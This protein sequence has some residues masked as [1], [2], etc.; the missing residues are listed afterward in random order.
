MT[1]PGLMTSAPLLVSSLIDHAARHHRSGEIVSRLGD[2]SLHRYRYPDCRRRAMRLASALQR[3][4]I[5]PGARI[6][7]IAWNGFR[8]LELYF[9]VGGMGAV[10]HTINPRLHPEQVA[11]IINHAA[12]Q[13]VFFDVEFTGLIAQIAPLCP[14]V[15]RWVALCGPTEMPEIPAGAKV[16]LESYELLLE[17][18]GEDYEW[19]LLEESAACG[20]CYTSGTTGQPKGVLYTHRSTVLHAYAASLPNAMNLSSHS[21]VLPV[22]PMFHVNAWGIPYAAPLNG[23]K[24][25]LPG[26]MLD[27]PSLYALMESEGV[28][29]A[30]GVPTIWLSLLE[31][32]EKSAV[33]F[34]A[35]QEAAIGGSACPA[36][37]VDRFH[38]VGVDVVHGWGMTETSPLGCLSRLGSGNA[39]LSLNQRRHILQKQGHA[40]FGIDMKIV[41][42]S[43]DELPWDGESFGDLM[44]RGPWVL[45]RYY[46]EDRPAGENGWFATG[47][48]AT[49]DPAG[50]MQI[51]DRTKD[52]IKSGG[53][54]I[55]SIDI[56]SIAM[57]HPGLQ[58]A[59]CIGAEHPKWG[60]RPLLIAVARPD[61]HLS[62]SDVLHF[63]E[64]KAAKWWIPDEVIFVESLPHN[65][66]G[67]VQKREL[68]DQYAGYFA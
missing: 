7:T 10:C 67:K 4:G 36:S 12:D 5:Q 63:F 9:G 14:E 55:S 44:V 8:H 57:A 2:G 16:S 65:A 19:P 50:S 45:E 25:V 28:T 59:A 52:I 35:L 46:G 40:L 41:N 38:A 49:I 32:V 37:L 20:L 64:G 17:T 61:T 42:G 11:Y 13:M 58:E 18:G 30:A 43:G 21:V 62:S 24:L 22:V 66:T 34:S 15:R 48:V 29:F 47:D 60:E 3:T 51:M 23:A 39:D 31:H 53:E 26:R 6:A 54:W 1:I 56:E 33:T 68:R 27:G